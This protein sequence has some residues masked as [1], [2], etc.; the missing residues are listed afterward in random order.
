[1]KKK[2][3]PATAHVGVLSSC[4]EPPPLPPPAAVTTAAPPNRRQKQRQETAIKTAET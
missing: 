4:L 1:M 2:Q 3:T